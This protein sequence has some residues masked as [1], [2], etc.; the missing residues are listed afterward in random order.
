MCGPSLLASEGL[1]FIF[2][3]G[4]GSDGC[5]CEG[6]SEKNEE[7]GLSGGGENRRHDQR[8]DDRGDAAKAGCSTG[9]ATANVGGVELRANRI[10][11]APSA[12]VEEG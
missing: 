10:E 7:P 1:S 9:A 12:E 2:R 4:K 3:K 6:A 5:D 11:R 8:G